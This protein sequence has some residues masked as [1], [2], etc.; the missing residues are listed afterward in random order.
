MECVVEQ[1]VRI[2]KQSAIKTCCLAKMIRIFIFSGGPQRVA[3]KGN[4]KGWN[5]GH[6]ELI[7]I[8]WNKEN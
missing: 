8:F 2:Q 3:Q 5:M 6:G 7:G 1:S 4:Y